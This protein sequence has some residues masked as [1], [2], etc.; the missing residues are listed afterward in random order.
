MSNIRRGDVVIE[1][2][3]K[4]PAREPG[5]IPFL[6]LGKYFI[7]LWYRAGFYRDLN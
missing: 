6:L 1:M 2:K 3:H 4:V 7:S 5:V